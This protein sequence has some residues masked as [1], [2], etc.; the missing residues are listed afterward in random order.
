M[1]QSYSTA[2]TVDQSP[3]EVFAAINNVR[4]WWSE[5][6]EG[7]TDEIGEF[8]YHYRD[9][10]RCTIQ[11][12]ELVPDK[13]VVWH[14]ADNYFNFVKDKNEWIDTDIVFEIEKKGGEAEVRFTHVGLSPVDECY[15]ICS[16]AWGTY[17]RGSLRDLIA[18]GKGKP[19]QN[20]ELAIKHGQLPKKE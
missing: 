10:H 3:E 14:I 20:E 11:I 5:E 6:I 15:E 18:T 8:K 4:G 2:F 19:N 7:K 9:I 12:T 13:K 1:N 16:D 17:I